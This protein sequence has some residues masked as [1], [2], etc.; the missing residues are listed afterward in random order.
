MGR[1]TMA[2]V[3]LRTSPTYIMLSSCV[4]VMSTGCYH[5]SI[6]SSPALIERAHSQLL[7]RQNQAVRELPATEDATIELTLDQAISL[8]LRSDADIKIDRAALLMAQASVSSST[9]LDNPQLRYS[10][11]KLESG[12]SISKNS[13]EIPAMT[14]P[15]T[16]MMMLVA[17]LS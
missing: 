5:S 17:H 7:E 8:A 9:Q 11:E 16:R 4:L 10:H 1:A 14:K 13:K 12:F 3:R 2:R 6:Q 15:V